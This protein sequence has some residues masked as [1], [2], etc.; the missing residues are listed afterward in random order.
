MKATT[1]TSSDAVEG[2]GRVTLYAPWAAGPDRAG[3]RIQRLA[4][5]DCW[6]LLPSIVVAVT[7]A[8]Q[9]LHR[10]DCTQFNHS[11]AGG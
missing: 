11:R 7:V 6:A 5:Q 8:G 1:L 3:R 10:S 2:R 4:A 9:L